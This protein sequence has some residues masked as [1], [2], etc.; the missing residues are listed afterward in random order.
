MPNNYYSN[1][2]CF[3]DNPFHVYDHNIYQPV[4]WERP[5]ADAN[6]SEFTME[7]ILF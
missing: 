5:P 2:V 4:G 7:V 6:L 3:L 1:D